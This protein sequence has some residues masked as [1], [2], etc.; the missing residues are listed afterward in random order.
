M[1]IGVVVFPGSNCD[2]DC[3]YVLSQILKV[4]TVFL[5]HKDHDLQG[6]QAVVLPGGFSY[7]DYLRCGAIANFSPIMAEV[8]RFAELGGSV[9]GI[10]NG[11]QILTESKLLPGV[12]MRNKSLKF[13]CDTPYLR[14][15]TK[16]S[17]FS[18]SYQVGQVLQ[19]PIAHMEGNYFIEA[20]GLKRLEDNDQVVFRYVNATGEATAESNPN[21]ALNNIAGIKNEQGNVVGMMPH[22]ERVSESILGS[23]DGIKVFES[24]L[25]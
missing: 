6:V 24:L 13:I 25:S 12:L 3:Y 15:E 11:F 20:E 19:I 17:Q 2:Y 23:V 18:K 7:G 10:C 8:R 14:V 22:P 1:K 21:G 9:L 16:H 4:E 5:W